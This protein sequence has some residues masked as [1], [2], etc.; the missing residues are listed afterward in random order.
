M[1][2]FLYHGKIKI[3]SF[4]YIIFCTCTADYMWSWDL[5]KL[6]LHTLMFVLWFCKRFILTLSNQASLGSQRCGHT[7]GLSAA[8]SNSTQR[9]DSCSPGDPLAAPP[10]ATLPSLTCIYKFV[11]SFLSTMTKICLTDTKTWLRLYIYF[12]VTR[13][14]NVGYQ[15][16]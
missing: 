13:T 14:R 4:F 6:S 16:Y 9:R 2:L 11:V 5:G 15:L 3:V 7:S 10:A 12:F 8:L 1:Y